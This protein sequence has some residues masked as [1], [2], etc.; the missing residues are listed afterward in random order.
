MDQP[1]EEDDELFGA[2]LFEAVQASGAEIP[3]EMRDNFQR[4][5]RLLV[6]AYVPENEISLAIVAA[7]GSMLACHRVN[8]N[9][10]G[11]VQMISVMHDALFTKPDTASLQ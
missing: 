11:A 6:S 4:M 8:T 2:L 1:T 3:D 5:A 7:Q 9:E 10:Q